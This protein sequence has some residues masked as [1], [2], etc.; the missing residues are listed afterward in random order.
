MTW[1]NR[2]R[3]ALGVLAVIALTLALALVFNHRQNQVASY[4]AEV[5]ADTYTVGADHP[6][7][8]IRQAVKAG[9][10]VTKGQLL[11]EVQS[12]QLKEELAN[13]LEVA[14]TLAYKVDDRRGVISYYAVTAGRVQELTAQQG[15][16]VPA[17]GSLATIYGSDRFLLAD[18]H[19]AP[20]DYAR[21][22]PGAPA[23]V[24]LPNNQVITAR[25]DNVAVASSAE[26]AVASLK[27][28]SEELMTMEQQTL[29][30]PGT[31]VIVTVQLTDSGPLAPITDAVNDLLQQVGLR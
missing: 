9:D 3:L 11:F 14:D 6:G 7:T 23:R 13:G 31:P 25:V 4:Q 1:Q 2:A 26:G 8:V 22:M 20:R 16:S 18:F 10:T 21:V 30:E 29:A 17:G 27:L 19:L 12:L 24:T 5:G 28:T 15:N